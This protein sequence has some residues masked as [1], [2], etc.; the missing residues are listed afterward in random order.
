V[1]N[2]V[3]SLGQTPKA[4]QLRQCALF[5]KA[6]EDYGTRVAKGLGLDLAKVKKLAAMTQEER[7]AATPVK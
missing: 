1:S 2:I 7:V 5:H 4:I 3:G 6:D